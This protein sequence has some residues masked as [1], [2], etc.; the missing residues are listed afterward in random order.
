M[1]QAIHAFTEDNDESQDGEDGDDGTDAIPPSKKDLVA[2][3]PLH[4]ELGWPLIPRQGDNT[5]HKSKSV[6]RA[7]VTSAYRKTVRLFCLFP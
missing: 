3:I 2:E 6:I 4:D 1:W 7:Y 5:L